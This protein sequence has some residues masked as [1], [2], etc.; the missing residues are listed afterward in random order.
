VRLALAKI[1][2]VYGT[3]EFRFDRIDLERC[4][5]LQNQYAS[6]LKQYR[7]TF[8]RDGF[9][10]CV[11]L[12]DGLLAD[13]SVLDHAMFAHRLEAL[14]VA[15]ELARGQPSAAML[16]LRTMLLIDEKLAA[17]PNVAVRR[18]AANL[19][20]EA[21]RAVQGLVDHPGC[22]PLLRDELRKVLEAQ[23]DRWTPDRVIMKGDRA[24]GIHAY[25]LV[26]D[27]QIKNLL[28]DEEI[29]RLNAADELDE[30]CTTVE[31]GV[32]EDEWFYL[33]AMRRLID[34]CDRPLHERVV[35][36]DEINREAERLMRTQLAPL[37]AATVLLPDMATIHF[38]LAIDRA[39]CEAWVMGLRAAAAEP[40][41]VDAVNPVTGHPYNLVRELDRIMV[42]K[43][44]GSRA[45]EPA[46][47]VSILP[48][49]PS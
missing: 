10:F 35:V 7:T 23:L 3:G 20:A 18:A 16:P 17:V 21:L 9:Q 15:D 26:R 49:R 36:L 19:R 11:S 43:L 2:P 4:R 12:S 40:V 39:R 30:F 33:S 24:L 46:V 1:E 48:D 47:A 32:D 28:T 27:G 22:S 42:K 44:G 31:T 8:H 34:A 13:L 25:E 45:E 41:D 5:K 37:F 29:E 38:E 14:C 6:E